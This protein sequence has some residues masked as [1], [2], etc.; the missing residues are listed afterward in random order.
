MFTIHTT[1]NVLPLLNEAENKADL[2][3]SHAFI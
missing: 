2:V 3:V 1:S